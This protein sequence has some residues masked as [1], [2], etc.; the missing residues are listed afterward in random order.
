MDGTFERQVTVWDK[1]QD[2]SVYQKSKTVWIAVGQY[3]GATIETKSSS[4][5]SALKLW[6]DAAK[7]RGNG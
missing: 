3:M 4:A 7:Y 6:V 1:R 5:N 2:V